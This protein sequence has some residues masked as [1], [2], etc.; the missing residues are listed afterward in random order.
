MAC[1]WHVGGGVAESHHSSHSPDVP[2]PQK[3]PLTTLS[4]AAPQ[5]CST[6]T[7]MRWASPLASYILSA[8]H[9]ALGLGS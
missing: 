6:R 7:M 5:G 3:P 9:P 1:E 4:K 8:I 2:S